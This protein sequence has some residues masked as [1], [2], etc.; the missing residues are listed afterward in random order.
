MSNILISQSLPFYLQTTAIPNSTKVIPAGDYVLAKV[1]FAKKAQKLPA[2]YPSIQV[3]LPLLTDAY[4]EYWL[5]NVPVEYGS[6]ASIQYSYNQDVLVGHILLDEADYPDLKIATQFAYQHIFELQAALAYPALLR[7][8]NYFPAITATQTQYNRY[9]QFCLGR[10][11]AIDEF[12][13][14][15][16]APP[17]ATAIGTQQAGLQIYFIAARSPGTQLENPRQTSAFLYPKQYGPVSPAFSRATFKAWSVA[18]H[19]YIS[20]TTSI[21]GHQTVHVGEPLKQLDE[22]LANLEALLQHGQHTLDLAIN[23]VA[24]L[25]QLKV[26]IHDPTYFPAIKTRL[27]TYLQ[28]TNVPVLYL[29]GDVCRADLM[30]E[31]EGIYA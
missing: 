1:S 4:T 11:A 28:G 2:K 25:S 12:K 5:S 30:V 24:Q 26:Y 22:T 3:G 18:Q 14:F 20:G 19:L 31:M 9:Q 13:Q 6:Y 27:D 23:Q 16:Y 8:W 15:A 17:A 29:Q 7:I 21:V 10:Q